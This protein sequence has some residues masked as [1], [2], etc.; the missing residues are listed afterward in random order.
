MGSQGYCGDA[1][2]ACGE[3]GAPG[4]FLVKELRPLEMRLRFPRRAAMSASG[5]A[6]PGRCGELSTQTSRVNCQHQAQARP[7]AR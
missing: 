7:V 5:S 4:A 2:A 1:L 3:A 6:E